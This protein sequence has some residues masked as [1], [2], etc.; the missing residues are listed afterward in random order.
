[1]SAAEP[2]KKPAAHTGRLAGTRAMVHWTTA[3]QLFTGPDGMRASIPGMPAGVTFG[4]IFN[5]D[6]CDT[7]PGQPAGDTFLGD[8]CATTDL[9]WADWNLV[10]WIVA[11]GIRDA[12]AAADS[13]PLA[14]QL[15]ATCGNGFFEDGEEC[16]AGQFRSAEELGLRDENGALCGEG[17]VFAC[18]ADCRA[19]VVACCGNG[20]LEGNEV[21]DVPEFGGDSC[22]QHGFALGDLH[23]LACAQIDASGCH[24]GVSLTPPLS[25]SACQVGPLDC[26]DPP[27]PEGCHTAADAGQCLGGPCVRTNP[28]NRAEGQLDPWSDFHPVGNFRDADGFL[29]RCDTS[30]LGPSTCVDV[31]GWGVC[32]RCEIGPD[33]LSTML[34]CPC[35]LDDDCGQDLQC[36]GGDFPYGGACWP[37]E[38]PPDFQC[39][40]GSC[41]QVVRDGQGGAVD[42]GSYCEHYPALGATQA[43]CMPQRCDDIGAQACSGQG[44]VCGLAS[45]CINECLD[46]DD[47]A[48]PGWPVDYVCGATDR[49]VSL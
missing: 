10:S 30:A 19:E 18:T 5:D 47:C 38:G 14:V 13:E 48:L 35:F 6:D 36:F 49:C 27:T 22:A 11:R 7:T 20:V 12:V 25:Y 28:Q 16:D 23:C 41:G 1:V 9:V 46:D 29:Y 31:D 3:D 34:G 44:L 15:C 43:V 42:G 45:D 37:A 4:V 39:R 33:P 21:C 2:I 8:D 40:E 32:M 17:S 24:D 26:G